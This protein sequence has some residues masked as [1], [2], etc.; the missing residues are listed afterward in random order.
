MGEQQQ[1]IHPQQHLRPFKGTVQADAHGGYQAIYKT[2][3]VT[4]AARWAHDRR[5][6]YELHAARPNALSTEALELSARY[7]GLRK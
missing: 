4:E 7:T 1:G 6:F 2:G 5:Q 3:R